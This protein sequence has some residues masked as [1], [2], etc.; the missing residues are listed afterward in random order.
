MQETRVRKFLLPPLRRLSKQATGIHIS[1]RSIQYAKLTPTEG[2][3]QLASFG[4][5]AL[6]PGIVEEG[7]ILSPEGLIKALS[8]IRSEQKVSVVRASIPEIAMNADPIAAIQSYVEVFA[9]AGLTLLSLELE[10]EAAARAVIK[11]GDTTA[12]LIVDFGQT[13]TSIALCYGAVI[14]ATATVEVGAET[15]TAA[16]AKRF[17]ISTEEAEKAK[18]DFGMRRDG[19][20]PDLF[21][22]LLAS[23]GV[24]RDEISRHFIYGQ[25]HSYIQGGPRLPIADIRLVGEGASL[26]GLAEYLAASLRAKVVLGNVWTNV[27]LPEN[28]VS[29][30]SKT[31]APKYATAI[32]LSH[33]RSWN[34]PTLL[35][36]LLGG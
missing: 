34:Q 3:F 18:R 29:E 11:K 33:P 1:D 9:A 4:E 27:S 14:H 21:S 32:G 26:P 36:K 28:G 22:V 30:L 31:E 10:A 8:N 15:L 13:H 7:K 25:G 5:V 35:S 24:L 6:P 12:H 20:H 16:I 2:S 19:A 23:V 17:G